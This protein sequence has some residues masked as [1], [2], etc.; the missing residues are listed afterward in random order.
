MRQDKKIQEMME[1][2]RDRSPPSPGVCLWPFAG[3]EAAISNCLGLF[4]PSRWEACNFSRNLT[5][6][7]I[8]RKSLHPNPQCSSG[9]SWFHLIRWE[10]C[11]STLLS[12]LWQWTDRGIRFLSNPLRCNFRGTKIVHM[13]SAKTVHHKCLLRSPYLQVGMSYFLGLS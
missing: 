10:A 2:R 3:C 1:H 6:K 11:Q 7:L 9:G 12:G 5:R 8:C 13:A 4:L